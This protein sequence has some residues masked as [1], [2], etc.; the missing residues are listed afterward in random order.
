VSLTLTEGELYSVTDMQRAVIDRLVK[1]SPVLQKLGFVTILGNSLTYDTIT[2]D[3]SA[4]FYSVN[5]TW[6]EST[7]SITQATAS[8]KIMAATLM[9]ITSCSRPGATKSTSRVQF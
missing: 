8:L 2:T 3:S 1:D 5:D 7:P 4:K 9:W 6:V